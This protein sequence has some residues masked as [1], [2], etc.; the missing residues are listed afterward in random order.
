M[1]AGINKFDYLLI[2]RVPV[3][4][5]SKNGTVVA[6]S[7]W[8]EDLRAE[9]RAI[10]ECGGRVTAA[11]PLLDNLSVS[12]SGSFDLCEFTPRDEGFELLALPWYSN[13]STY[14]RERRRIERLLT[15]SFH[16]GMI[17]K[18]DPSGYPLP[19]SG[20]VWKAAGRRG[21]KRIWCFD[22][23]DLIGQMHARV[24]STQGIARRMMLRFRN[25][26]MIRHCRDCVREA[27]LVFSHNAATK[28]HLANVWGAHCHEF[29]RSFVTDNLVATDAVVRDRSQALLDKTIPL[30]LA[31]ASRLISI[32]AIDHVLQAVSVARQ[33]AD[34]R[35]DVF[36]DG[37]EM[38]RLREMASNLGIESAVTFHGSIPYGASLFE[39]LRKAHGMV[40]TNIVPE[41]SRNLLLAMALGL[42]I[43]A[44]RNEGSDSMLIRSKAAKLVPSG[45]WRALGLELAA[46]AI[47]RNRILECVEL[48][49]QFARKT[50][51]DGCHRQRA[52]LIRNLL[53]NNSI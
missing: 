9:A 41:L 15:A 7:M 48:G 37:E 24:A 25:S 50:T 1:N 8:L 27:D 33:Q 45:D 13:W 44:Y 47:D 26:C 39:E 36:G 18:M 28:V 14:F 21:C 32:K 23:G 10:D 35:L 38:P 11:L 30:R 53:P 19:L 12:K 43:F 22:G 17:V 29:D 6:G 5:G 2:N 3:G 46:S 52:S 4:K 49:V 20:I 40:V 42:P 51:L 34:V 16:P 31:V